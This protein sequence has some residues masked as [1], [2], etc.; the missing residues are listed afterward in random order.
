LDSAVSL[1]YTNL[2][3]LDTHK[4]FSNIR[5]EQ[6]FKVLRQRVYESDFP[7][8]AN[9]KAREF[10]F[11]I[12]DWEVYVT[13]TQTYAGHNKIEMVSGGCALLE[14]WK[15]NSS[16]GKSLNFIDPLSGKWKQTWVG[17]YPS[18]IQEF[19]QGAYK[20]GAM[21]FIFETTDVLGNK[22]MGRFIFYNEKQGQVRQFN[23]TS[24]D[25]GKT[26]STSYDYTYFR[27]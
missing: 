11:W 17:S 10:D 7:C 23:E 3:V 18:G 14:N 5:N 26:W 22:L 12:G 20:D 19:V 16:E 4:E 21:R 6:A 15:S 27:K 24:A 9:S 1:G 13:G 25:S 2:N 8:M